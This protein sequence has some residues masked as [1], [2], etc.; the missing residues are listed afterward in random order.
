M[1]LTKGN[2]AVLLRH[3]RC[4]LATNKEKTEPAPHCN[5]KAVNGE[6]FDDASIRGKVVLLEF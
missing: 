3:D 6:K 5:V 2:V 4:A 1:P